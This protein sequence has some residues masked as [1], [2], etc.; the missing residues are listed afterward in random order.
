MDC[1]VSQVVRERK[2]LIGP[3]SLRQSSVVCRDRLPR[4]MGSFSA[5]YMCECYWC[6]EWVHVD[7]ILDWIGRPL[8]DAC[9]DMHLD[10]RGDGVPP[11][12]NAVDHRA[13]AL[14]VVLPPLAACGL[15]TAVLVAS[16]LECPWRPGA[17]SRRTPAPR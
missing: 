7:Y 10:E 15:D 9:Y 8:C 6:E 11:H 2:A 17:G 14:L 16:F 5:D 4:T 12:P 1:K 3:S 13:V